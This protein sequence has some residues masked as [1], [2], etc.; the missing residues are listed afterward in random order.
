MSL[1]QVSQ[2]VLKQIARSAISS[3]GQSVR[4][5]S[6]TGMKQSSSPCPNIKQSFHYEPSAPPLTLY[7]EEENAFRETVQR[8]AKEKIEPLVRQMDAASNMEQSVIDALFENG[9]MG[10]DVDPKYNGTGST[11]FTTMLVIEELSKVDPSVGALVEV[12][13][14]LVVETFNKYASEE[15]KEQWLPRLSTDM[16]GSFCLS[17]PEAGSDAFA[18][19]TKAEKDGDH[20]ILNG[21]KFW[22][23]NADVAGCFLIF[24]NTDFSKG[25]RGITCFIVPGDT[26]GL[27]VSRKEDKLGIRASSSCPV[28]LED[29]RVPA[30][31][32][33]GKIG[34]GYK[35]SIDILNEGRI[36]IGAQMV[37]LA[38]GCYDHA[39]RY[40][41]ERKQFGKPIFD[42]QGM[43]HQLAII[44]AQ[45]ESARLLVYNA[46]R[47]REAG[48]PFIK[49]AAM[50]K[51]ITAEVATVA[52]SKCVEWLGGVGFTKDYP[53]EKYYR[54][55]KIGAIYEGTNNV[56]L[57]TIAKLLHKEYSSLMA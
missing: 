54:D 55:C 5:V 39:F 9:L 16:V 44:A 18:L 51:Y 47:L 34:E 40:T 32:I 8:M 15:Q 21:T 45:I 53:V 31:N 26:P 12:H 42:F 19:K 50:A 49:E 41:M 25:Y 24:A 43:Q 1:R 11:F 23:S 27:S 4:C 13:N 56:Q 35:Y 28:V 29:V 20:Y 37:G 10:I 30:S 38:Q 7:N 46:A 33:I 22:I 2:R 14:S 48:R 57:N 6:G 17:E 52:T 36:G 3:T